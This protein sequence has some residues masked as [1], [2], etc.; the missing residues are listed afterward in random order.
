[1]EATQKYPERVQE[2]KMITMKGNEL[3]ALRNTLPIFKNGKQLKPYQIEMY[4]KES[5][6]QWIVKY[7]T[8]ED[9]DD[10]C[11]PTTD[12]LIVLGTK[13]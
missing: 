1:M 6:R 10:P 5:V 4:F 2:S 13:F 8:L 12:Q 9:K 11:F 7:D 3:F